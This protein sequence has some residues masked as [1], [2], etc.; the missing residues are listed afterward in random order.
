[1]AS[2]GLTRSGSAP[3]FEKW[4]L[5]KK[6]GFSGGTLKI[7]RSSSV[8]SCGGNKTQ[9]Q[10]RCAFTRKC[11]RLVKEQRARFYIM[12]RCVIMLICWRDNYSDS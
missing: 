7:T 1:M 5:S 6:D 11:A 12:R 3:Q 9:K 8:S 4:K 10:G 2:S